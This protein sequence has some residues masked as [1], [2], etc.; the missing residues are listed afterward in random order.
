M[1]AF[2]LFLSEDKSYVGCKVLQD[3]TPASAVEFTLPM[4]VQGK[5]FGINKFLVDLR[6]VRNT[7]GAGENYHF[8]REELQELNLRVENYAAMITD[9]EDRSHDFVETV[10]Q[11]AGHSVRVFRNEAGAL[12]WLQNPQYLWNKIAL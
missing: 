12:Q 4:E 8:A 9:P 7:A 11:N 5:R 2:T 10:T 3:V 6:G 1:D